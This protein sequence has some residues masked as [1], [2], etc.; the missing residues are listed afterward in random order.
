MMERV[1]KDLIPFYRRAE[2]PMFMIPEI[3]NLGINGMIVDLHQEGSRMTHLEVGALSYELAR[4]DASMANFYLTHNF[5]GSVV[6]NELG[7]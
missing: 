2:F 6:I 1:Y 7:N 3:Q 4:R 5:D